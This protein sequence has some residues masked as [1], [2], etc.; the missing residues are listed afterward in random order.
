MRFSST[1]DRKPILIWKKTQLNMQCKKTQSDMQKA[2]SDT[3]E[4]PV[5]YKSESDTQEKQADTQENPV[6]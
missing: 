1:G 3:Q 6:L 4:N 5:W 2:Q